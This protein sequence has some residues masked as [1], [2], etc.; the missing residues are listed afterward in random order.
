MSAAIRFV[1]Y[2][3]GRPVVSTSIALIVL[4]AA[5]NYWLWRDRREIE[6]R[7]DAAKQK[8]E[9]MLR[10]LSGRAAV[11]A[12]L[13]ALREAVAQIDAN[14][15]DEQSMEVNLGYFYRFE[16]TTRVRL[17][18]LNQLSSQPAQPGSKFKVV[19]FSLQI[20]GTYRNNMAFLRALETGPRILR[21]RSSSLE[22]TEKDNANLTL[23]LMVD[24]LA[25]A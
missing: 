9:F 10:A 12:N 7:L 5:A 2:L 13:A 4:L 24:V 20:T 14:L 21:I 8:G 11:D 1:A 6:G 18:R 15:L 16:R 19:S 17:V 23:D 3:R 25:K 22:R